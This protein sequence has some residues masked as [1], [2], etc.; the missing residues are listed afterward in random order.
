MK[1]ET[2]GEYAL[3]LFILQNVLFVDMSNVYFIFAKTFH[4]LYRFEC[5]VSA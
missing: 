1:I 3:R 2:A 5:V 4:F